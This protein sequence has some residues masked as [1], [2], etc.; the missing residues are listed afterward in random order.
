M[1]GEER[2]SVWLDEYVPMTPPPLSATQVAAA[3][4]ELVA[5]RAR[6]EAADNEPPVPDLSVAMSEIRI[7]SGMMNADAVHG[8]FVKKEE[9]EDQRITRQTQELRDNHNGHT[10]NRYSHATAQSNAFTISAAFDFDNSS[11]NWTI[12]ND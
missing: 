4:E 5:E 9:T 7:N 3:R 2:E 6:R 12:P 1:Q 11:G 8:R 10:K